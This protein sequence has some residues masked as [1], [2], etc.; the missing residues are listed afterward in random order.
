[1]LKTVSI[2]V[3][4][5]VQGVFYRQSTKEKATSLHITGEVKNMPDDTVHI[6]ATGTG[7]QIEQLVSWC[8][9]GPPKA[10]VAS[11]FVT[12]IFFASI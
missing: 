6:I 2:I 9:Q 7:E 3:T 12:A 11:V 5:K 10:R 4:G 1:M 8:K